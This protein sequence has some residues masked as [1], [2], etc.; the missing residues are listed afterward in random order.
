MS[1]ADK[2]PASGDPGQG[3]ALEE[4]KPRLQ[5]PPLY[6]VVMINDDYTPMEFVV[7]VLQQ[8]FHHSRSC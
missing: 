4:A 6:K 1:N 8:F 2:R 7:Q 3:V 5:Q